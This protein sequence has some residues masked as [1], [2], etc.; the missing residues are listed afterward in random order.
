M[1]DP[2]AKR[3]DDLAG[4]VPEGEPPWGEAVAGYVHMQPSDPDLVLA[5]VDIDPPGPVWTGLVV[6]D[7]GVIAPIARVDESLAAVL[8]R[9]SLEGRDRTGLRASSFGFV[10][11]EGV[12]AIKHGWVAGPPGKPGCVEV[13]ADLLLPVLEALHDPDREIVW[14]RDPDFGYEVPA[15]V[16]GLDEAA[17]RILCPRLH[18]AD[19]DRVYE[20]AELVAQTKQRWFERLSEMEGVTDEVLAATGWPPQPTGS[21]WRE[22]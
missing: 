1:A 13:G 18:Y 20:H 4:T 5:P 6:R 7:A 10:G 17:A 22:R 2:Y 12:F 9:V 21:E 3:S 16:E 15:R 11:W 19:H 8:E 14:E